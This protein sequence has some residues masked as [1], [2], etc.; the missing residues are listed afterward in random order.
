MARIQGRRVAVTG[1]SGFVGR[2]LV[3]RLRE[4]G[5]AVIALGRGAAGA[6]LPDDVEFRRF[7]P[8]A[9]V[10][11]PAAFEGADAVLHLAGEPVAGRWTPGKKHAIFAS[12][13]DG[14]R[15]VV[16]S[17]AASTQ[18]PSVLV[19]A[20]ATGYYGARGDERLDEAAPPGDDFL[21]RVCLAW[22][23][24]AAAAET[25]GIRSVRLR[26]GIVLGEG[27][28]LTAMLPLFRT[29]LGGSFGGGSQ[30]LP[31]I[32][33]D[34]LIELYLFA[35]ERTDIAGALNAVTPDYATNAR[36]AQ[37]LGAALH[38]PALL[39]APAFALRAVLGEFAQTLLGSQLVLPARAQDAGFTW[40]QPYLED[41]LAAALGR[42]PW[43]IVKTYSAEQF[44][45]LPREE[46]FPF[47][48][49][50]SNL[51]SITPASL[52]FHIRD[53]PPEMGRGALIRYVLRVHG[54]PLRWTTMISRWDPP[55]GFDDVQLHGPYALWHHSHSFERVAGGTLMNDRVRY[56]LPLHP[57]GE[58][59]RQLVERD[60]EQIFSHRRDAIA[61]LRLS[62]AAS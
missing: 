5:Y 43:P 40:R 9:G 15:T 62:S 50:A 48:A 59:A 60:V 26:T 20:S 47:F 32:H 18:R 25:L 52:R 11:D 61:R 53:A 21:A 8:G 49:A 42:S 46:V 30:F 27:G 39:P 29:G 58:L 55:Y 35:F 14:T 23:R 37:A 16:A 33:L 1:A 54:V 28:A 7:D 24:E 38:R 34:D 19:C 31:W 2:A 36:F 45:P 57:L 6:G 17:L 12:R 3:T 51:E 10:P 56:A 44:L 22:E 13:V 41:A 4:R